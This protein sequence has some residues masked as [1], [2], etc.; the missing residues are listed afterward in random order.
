[1]LRQFDILRLRALVAAAKQ[2]DDRV[3]PLLKIDAVARAVVNAQ[4]PDTFANRLDVAC[5]P[6]GQPIQPRCDHR[7][8]TMVLEPQSPLS[9]RF[10]LPQL[11]RVVY[12]LRT[13]EDQTDSVIT[14]FG[15]GLLL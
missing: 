7:T 8:G 12:E 3:S 15:L 2:N 5:V 4:F 11:H 14:P 10:T 13:F 1:M 9:K 6:L